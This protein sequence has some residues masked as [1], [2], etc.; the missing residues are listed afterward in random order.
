MVSFYHQPSFL[1][2]Y[3][4]Q[5]EKPVTSLLFS[6][7]KLSLFYL[8]TL[9]F[10]ITW[11]LNL[12][13]NLKKPVTSP[14][15]Y[16]WSRL[17]LLQQSHGCLHCKCCQTMGNQHLLVKEQCF[18]DLAYVNWIVH[19]K[20]IFELEIM[21]LNPSMIMKYFFFLKCSPNVDYQVNRTVK[22]IIDK[23]WERLKKQL[24]CVISWMG[25]SISTFSHIIFIY[26]PKQN[27]IDT[28]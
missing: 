11:F 6:I 1:K 13:I 16:R 26:H 24:Y 28:L 2:L 19:Y 5:F 9:S 18:L 14:L 23:F 25:F 22:K 21:S 17:L 20:S 10:H 7:W 3:L 15:F 27:F 8:E 12:K 4:K